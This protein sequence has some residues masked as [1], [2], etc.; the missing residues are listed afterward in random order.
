MNKDQY[1]ILKEAFYQDLDKVQEDYEK[2]ILTR[3]QCIEEEK[4]VFKQLSDLDNEFF[5]DIP[6]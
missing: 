6:L 4:K 1:E 3:E 5:G 2:G